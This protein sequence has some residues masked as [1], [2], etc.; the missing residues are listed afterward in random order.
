MNAADKETENAWTRCIHRCATAE[1]RQ[2]Y[3]AAKFAGQ[4][5]RRP[6]GRLLFPEESHRPRAR[7]DARPELP[8]YQANVEYWGSS[9]VNPDHFDPRAICC[10]P[11]LVTFALSDRNIGVDATQARQH[12]F[13]RREFF[14]FLESLLT[15]G[16]NRPPLSVMEYEVSAV[17]ENGSY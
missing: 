4:S 8:R 6:I 5:R 9:E 14:A 3:T 7:S 12:E 17:S 11:S 16:S 10:F 2:I 13:L 15:A 1:R